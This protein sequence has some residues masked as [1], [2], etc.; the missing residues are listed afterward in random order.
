MREMEAFILLNE[1]GAAQKHNLKD[2]DLIFFIFDL[3]LNP[4]CTHTPTQMAVYQHNALC[5]IIGNRL[6]TMAP[7]G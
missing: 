3:Y 5:F 6:L 1:E 4:T 2:I 7:V